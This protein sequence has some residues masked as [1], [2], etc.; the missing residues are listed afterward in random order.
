MEVD[1]II[2]DDCECL[3]EVKP[4]YDVDSCPKVE[5]C[6]NCSSGERVVGSSGKLG[7][8]VCIH[9]SI[10]AILDPEELGDGDAPCKSVVDSLG[11]VDE[12]VTCVKTEE[13]CVE[14]CC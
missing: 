14:V 6:C 10:A 2:P 8:E 1:T 7:D 3:H 5:V 4:V 11:K 12:V 9:V 13:S